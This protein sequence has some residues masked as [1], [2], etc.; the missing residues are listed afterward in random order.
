MNLLGKGSFSL[1]II[2]H[3]FCA[4][5]RQSPQKKKK[6]K[7]KTIPP[8]H[9]PPPSSHPFKIV[10]RLFSF[11]SPLPIPIPLANWQETNL[12]NSFQPPHTWLTAGLDASFH[13]TR[14]G[15]AL[16]YPTSTKYQP[17]SKP[18]NLHSFSSFPSFR[19]TFTPLYCLL[20][21]PYFHLFLSFIL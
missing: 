6:K 7:K 10:V 8:S 14:G 13:A 21:F 20:N 3:S 12:C 19:S 1:L 5:F 2:P 4:S 18:L 17:R 16:P 15:L 9:P 11:L